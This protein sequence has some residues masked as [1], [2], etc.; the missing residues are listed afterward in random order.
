MSCCRYLPFYGTLFV[1][2]LVFALVYGGVMLRKRQYILLLQ[3]AILGVVGFGVLETAL[4]FFTY[5]AKN[6]TVRAPGLREA[7]QVQHHPS[8][9]FYT[10][11]RLKLLLQLQGIPTPCRVCGPP[12]ADYMAAVVVSV[13]KRAVSRCLLLAVALGF[14]VVHPS[15]SRR[16]TITTVALGIAYLVASLIYDVSRET[17]YD[18]AAPTIWELPVLVLDMIFLMGIYGGLGKLR[19]ELQAAGQMVCSRCEGGREWMCVSD[20]G[21][22]SSIILSLVTLLPTPCRPSC[23]CTGACT[24]CWWPISSRGSSSSAS[25]C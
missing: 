1:V 12:T 7:W 18:S 3:Y 20:G 9:W 22:A 8:R 21:C 5:N 11:D 15:L 13:F 2:Y 24:S 25:R 16:A 19:R 6:E 4:Y 14:G 23:C 17:A 10:T